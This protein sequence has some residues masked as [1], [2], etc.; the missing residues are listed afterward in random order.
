MKL[1]D[2]LKKERERKGISAKAMAETLGVAPSDYDQIEGG[3]SDLETY[4]HFLTNFAKIVDQPVNGLFYPCGL[5][6][7]EI[8]DYQISVTPKP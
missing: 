8:E 1:G 5:P 6:F 4:A 3:S 7:Q 2:V